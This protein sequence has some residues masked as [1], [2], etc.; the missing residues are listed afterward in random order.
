MAGN[1]SKELVE[2]Y[3]KKVDSEEYEDL[4]DLLDND[5]TYE[6][7]YEQTFTGLD[8]IKDFYQEEIQYQEIEHNLEQILVDGDT[9]SVR[10]WTTGISKT[11]DEIGARFAL[12]HTFNNDGKIEKQWGYIERK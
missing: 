9:A 6:K 3:Y 11:G 1:A 2:K 8:E 4:F 10:G 12:F 7:N 5:I